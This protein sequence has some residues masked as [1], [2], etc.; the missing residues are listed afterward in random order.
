MTGDK[1]KADYKDG[2]LT[3]T[4]PKTEDAKPKQIEVKVSKLLKTINPRGKRGAGL[5]I[6]STNDAANAPERS[7]LLFGYRP[8][9]ATQIGVLPQMPGNSIPF[10]RGDSQKQSLDV[11]QVSNSADTEDRKVIPLSFVPIARVS[12]KSP[13]KIR[14][15]ADVIEP[16]SLVERINSSVVGHDFLQS[17]AK[18]VF[19]E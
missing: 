3:I 7:C 15:E 10:R 13:K 6:F 12:V 11:F 4:L 14:S 19:V 2:I 9:N 18:R 1:V 16:L 5:A 17:L 8:Q